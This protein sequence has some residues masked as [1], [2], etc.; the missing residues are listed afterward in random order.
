LKVSIL[1]L[2]SGLFDKLIP[3]LFH[4][5]NTGL[6]PLLIWHN[7]KYEEPSDMTLFGSN[8]DNSGASKI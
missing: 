1:K 6:V 7:N 2:D 4:W 5:K 8:G 3:F